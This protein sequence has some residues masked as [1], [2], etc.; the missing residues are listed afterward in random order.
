MTDTNHLRAMVDE[1]RSSFDRA[2]SEQTAD[3]AQVD[4]LISDRA[5][6]KRLVSEYRILR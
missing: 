6:L 3:D 2:P 4:N 5:A 1:L